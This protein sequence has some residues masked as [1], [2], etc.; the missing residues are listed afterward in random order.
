[1]EFGCGF[2]VALGMLSPVVWLVL[3]RHRRTALRRSDS[4][5]RQLEELSRL[6][7]GLAH[8][9]KN[10]LST[11]KV[12]LKLITEDVISA[13]QQDQRWFRKIEVVE[14]ETQRLEQI[15][16]DFLRYIGKAEIRPR[17]VD[18][19]ELLVEMIDFYLPQAQARKITLRQSPAE[20]SLLCDIDSDMI[21]QVIL[22]LFINAQQAM[23]D[24]GELI[25]R[26][27]NKAGFAVIEISDTGLGIEPEK[28]D[29]IFEAYYT[30]RPGGSGLGLPT[31]RKI[32]EAHKGTMTVTSQP[33]TGTSFCIELP[34][35]S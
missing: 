14:K 33:G 19:N 4:K 17:K 27:S 34:L 8:E 2:V 5:G 29:K 16:D 20:E 25:V 28:L 12:N 24:G 3:R 21:K 23:P 10:P 26:T 15:L 32:I 1:V 30:T 22:N 7:G 13:H 31:A 11:I 6:T 35:K 18:I 9:I